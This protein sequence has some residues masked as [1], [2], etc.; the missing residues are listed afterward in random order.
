MNDI[1]DTI[2][3]IN[4]LNRKIQKILYNPHRN[5]NSSHTYTNYNKQNILFEKYK[6]IKLNK[7]NDLFDNDSDNYNIKYENGCN[8]EDYLRTKLK[9]M[10]YNNESSKENNIN[11]FLINLKLNGNNNRNIVNRNKQF[12]RNNTNNNFNKYFTINDDEKIDDKYIYKVKEK[13]HTNENKIYDYRNTKNIFRNRKRYNS[14]NTEL[15]KKKKEEIIDNLKNIK[16]KK[17]NISEKIIP[18]NNSKFNDEKKDI[19]KYSINNDDKTD[20]SLN[21]DYGINNIISRKK[22]VE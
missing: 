2:N 4:H 10:N 9:Y 22:Y 16:Y 12:N 5:Y 17:I 6:Q 20:C 7:L 3:K 14:L 19:I 13:T 21:Y 11:E 8:K 18:F 1:Y 15:N